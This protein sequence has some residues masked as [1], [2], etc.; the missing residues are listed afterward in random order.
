MWFFCAL[1]LVPRIHPSFLITQIVPPFP[2]QLIL[3]FVMFLIMAIFAPMST[4]NIRK[5]YL[6]LHVYGGV[7]IFIM[8]GVT[9]LLGTAEKISFNMWVPLKQENVSI[10]LH[11]LTSSHRA[12]YIFSGPPCGIIFSENSEKIS[13]SMK[14]C[15]D[16]QI[17]ASFIDISRIKWL[18]FVIAVVFL[19]H[20]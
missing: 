17:N 15:P 2:L 1:Y 18:V 11:L 10:S 5:V 8:A 3:G 6:H 16:N 12:Y 14:R 13:L 4:T 19:P 20:N 7:L 9:S